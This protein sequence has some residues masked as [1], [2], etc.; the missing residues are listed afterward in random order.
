[1]YLLFA[2]CFLLYTALMLSPA[3]FLKC[4]YIT[5]LIFILSGRYFITP[6]SKINHMQFGYNLQKVFEAKLFEWTQLL[7]ILSLLNISIIV[8]T[9]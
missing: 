9:R 8:A 1:M 7:P 5:F 4:A 2:L 6:F 3:I